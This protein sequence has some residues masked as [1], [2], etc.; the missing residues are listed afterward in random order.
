MVI[1]DNKDNSALYVFVRL[2]NFK[3]DEINMKHSNHKYSSLNQRKQKS[4]ALRELFPF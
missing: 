4:N 3:N 2:T 1:I